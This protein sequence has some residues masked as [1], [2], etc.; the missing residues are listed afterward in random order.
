M[1]VPLAT[2]SLAWYFKFMRPG[3]NITKMVVRQAV[4][5][6]TIG[7][8]KSRLKLPLHPEYAANAIASKRDKELVNQSALDFTGSLGY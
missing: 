6:G 4:M 1:G 7:C 2:L 5:K 8:G 3:D